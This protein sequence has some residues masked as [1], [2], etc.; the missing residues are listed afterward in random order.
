MLVGPQKL[1]SPP[2]RGP[3]CPRILNS[4]HNE[5]R[6]RKALGPNWAFRQL[7]I[8]GVMLDILCLTLS[9]TIPGWAKR[10]L[11]SALWTV[12]LPKMA[13]NLATKAGHCSCQDQFYLVP[14][15]FGRYRKKHVL[16]KLVYCCANMWTLYINAPQFGLR[17]LRHARAT[18][19]KAH[20]HSGPE[21][22]PLR[23]LTSGAISGAGCWWDNSCF[24]RVD[25]W[26]LASAPR[27]WQLMQRL[28]EVINIL[29]KSRWRLHLRLSV[30]RR[31]GCR[32]S[33]RAGGAQKAK[34]AKNDRNH[35]KL[36]SLVIN[37][38][39]I[40]LLTSSSIIDISGNLSNK[41][42]YSPV[43]RHVTWHFRQPASH[44][45]AVYHSV[46]LR[47]ILTMTVPTCVRL[48]YSR[49]LLVSE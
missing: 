47:F 41:H 21:L 5:E 2:P 39:D 44:S 29:G 45:T 18:L 30:A 37:L 4:D 32:P 48:S 8:K 25:N 40:H 19:A 14:V 46:D 15:I 27:V 1:P 22:P 3:M 35:L 10:K 34:S 26:H 17:L 36:P 7:G 49:T 11:I 16:C 20:Y 12:K 9:L 24:A 31:P 28:I 43:V 23:P 42:L 6:R 13:L 38:I 33:G